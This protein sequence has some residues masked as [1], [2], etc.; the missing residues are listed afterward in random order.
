MS[1]SIQVNS[2]QKGN[3]VLKYIK[4]T[5][6]EQC[7]IL[8]DY[9]TGIGHCVLFLSC[10]YHSLHPEYLV[11]RFRKLGDGFKLRILLVQ[12]DLEDHAAILHELGIIGVQY[13]YTLLVTWHA[14]EAA[15]YLETLKAME[16]KPPDKLKAKVESD[17]VSRLGAALAEI[18]SV[19]STDVMTLLS[20]F[21]S[22]KGII[23]ADR[24]LISLLPGF[25]ASKTNRLMS[26]FDQP[27]NEE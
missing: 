15:L 14:K 10:R 18:K 11:S 24:D 17:A 25:G 5:Q 19:N 12:V 26:A 21:G 20:N 6:W 27:F 2:N 13:G 8:P 23:D 1:L 3:P 9:S 16:N 7:D 4:R 22:L